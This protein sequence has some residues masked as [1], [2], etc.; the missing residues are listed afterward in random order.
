MKNYQTFW[1][2]TCCICGAEKECYNNPDPIREETL[3]CCN[4]CNDLLV[5][6]ARMR[7]FRL[8]EDEQLNY[9]DRLRNMSYEELCREFPAQP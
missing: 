6:E 3:N 1:L 7:F 4:D 9:I 2:Q 5:R 8:P